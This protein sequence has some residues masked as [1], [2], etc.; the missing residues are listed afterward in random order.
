[1]LRDYRVSIPY[2]GSGRRKSECARS[3][4]EALYLVTR[5]GEASRVVLLWKFALYTFKGELARALLEEV[6]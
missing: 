3:A 5:R 1:M 6:R 2:W 4:R